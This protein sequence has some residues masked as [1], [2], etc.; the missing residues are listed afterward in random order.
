MKKN[1]FIQGAMIA[2]IGIVI[3]KI[4]G[5]VYVIPFY[6]IIGE[7][8]GALYGYAYSIYMIFL[9]LSSVG[10][11][12]AI[13]RLTSEYNALNEHELKE[14]T[15]RIGRN[16]ITALSLISFVILFLFAPSIA[17]IF[18]GDIEGGNTIEDVAF[19]IRVISTA[20]LVVPT[21][22]VTKGY[23]QGHRYITPTATSQ[24]IEQL[25]RVVVIIAGSYIAVKVLG[26]PIKVGVGIATFGATV[27]GFIAYLYLKYKMHKNRHHF[28][29]DVTEEKS[30]KS[31]KDI[32]LK[33]LSHAAPFI[34]TSLILSF[35]TFVDLATVVK[36]MVNGLSYAV[37]ESETVV[38]ILSTWGSK[39]NMIIASI[40]TG[41]VTSL[42]PN[43][44]DSFVKNDIKDVRYKINR[45]LQV[46][47]YVTIPMT[48]GLSLLAAPVWTVFY[49][50]SELSTMIFRYYI[51]TSLFSCLLTTLNVII[52][53][54]N[55]QGKMLWYILTG[56]V[57]KII[58]NVPLMYLFNNLGLHA[59]YGVITSTI[60]GF[61][62]SSFLILRRLQKKVNVS[63]TDT[64]KKTLS[65]TLASIIMVIV[66]LAFDAIIPLSYEHR[67]TSL[68]AVCIF[69]VIGAVVFAFVT[70]KQGIM[71]D[72]LGQ[73]TIDKI[74]RKLRLKKDK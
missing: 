73:P 52:Q 65:I 51:F 62:V 12:L 11:P 54:L 8:G 5:I 35:Y 74:L 67:M 70:F 61:S 21:L 48:V 66:V 33:I 63:Y 15:F 36:T 7:K 10:I 16:V 38:S 28:E 42:I 47:L 43:I 56:F 60:I 39:L 30:K 40:G 4:L 32:I 41:L 69:S 13:S 24:I 53:S 18:I 27:G 34:V 46:L 23:L 2:T 26:L 37:G 6:A 31:T 55:E 45:S 71:V 64:I 72:I 19:V 1:P 14:R 17:H 3:S 44:T 22:S 50:H 68:V 57:I 29:H 9:N 58:L 25:A 59:G 20:I 49:S